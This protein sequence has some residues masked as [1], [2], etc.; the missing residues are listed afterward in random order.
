MRPDIIRQKTS[1]DKIKYMMHP[2]QRNQTIH[3]N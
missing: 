3:D 1:T 2:M